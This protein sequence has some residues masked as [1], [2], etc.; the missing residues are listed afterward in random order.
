LNVSYRIKPLY[1]R[2]IPN[3]KINL[4]GDAIIHLAGKAH[5]TKGSNPSHYEGNFEL[6]QVF[7]FYNQK[8]L[9]FY[10]DEYRKVCS[11][12]VDVLTE[13]A[14]PA[15]NI[16]VLLNYKEQYVLSKDLPSGKEFI[17]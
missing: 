8:H 3:Q 17:F 11:Q 14:I 15:P 10:F 2:Y 1:V 9:F 16:M 13:E 5:D 4:E 12:V 6:K 7:D